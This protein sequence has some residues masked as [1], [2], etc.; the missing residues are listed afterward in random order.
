MNGMKKLWISFF[1]C[2]FSVYSQTVSVDDASYSSSQLV[3]LLLGNSCVEVSNISTSSPQSVAFFTNNGSSFPIN[4]GIL[5]RNGLATHTQGLYSGSNLSSQINTNSDAYLQ[6][7]SNSVGQTASITDVGFLEFDFIPLSS[8]FSFDFLFASNEYGQYQCG[9]SDV[10]AFVLTNLS[11]G[12]STNLAVIPGTSTPVTVKDIRDAAYN[13]ACASS[14][15][16]FFSVYN[17]TNVAASTINM[18][19]H[20]VVMN[21]SSNVI[22]NTPYKIRLVIGDYN[23]SGYDSAV[24]LKAGSFTTTLNLGSDRIICNGDTFTLNTN[25]DTS[26]SYTW[27]LNG[28]PINGATNSSYQ[29]TQSGTYTVEATKGSCIITDTIVFSDLAV[30]NPMN[31]QTCNTGDAVYSYDLTINNETQLGIDPATYDVFYYASLADVAANTPIGTPNAFSSDGGQIVYLKIRNVQTGNFC[32]TVY[33]FLLLVN[34]VPTATQPATVNLCDNSTT[35]NYTLNALDLE[36]LNGLLQTNYTVSYYATQAEATTGMNPITVLTIPVG[37]TTTTVYIRMHDNLNPNCFDTTSVNFTVNPLPLVSDFPDPIECSSF[38]LPVIEHG[39]YYSGTGGTGIHYNPGDVLTNGGTYYIYSGPDTSGCTNETT[40]TL[41]LIDEYQLALNNCGTFTVPFPPFNVGAFYT[42]SG[43]PSGGGTLIAPGTEYVNTTQTNQTHD[44]YYYAELD[45]AFCRD[46]LFTINVR[47]IPLVDDPADVVT[48]DSYQLPALVNGSYFSGTGGTGT[49]LF[50]GQFITSS[51]TVYVYATN[52]FCSKENSFEVKIVD[53]SLYTTIHACGQYM[54]PPI[55]F[56]G[57]FTQPFGGGVSVDPNIPITSSQII[58]YFAT[59]TTLPNC[60]NNLKYN[61]IIHELPVVDS[62]SS[63]TFCGQ[64][65]L[66]P[67]TNGV[68]FTLPGGPSVVGQTQLFA[69]QIID[70]TGTHLNPGTYYI[71]KSPDANGCANQ[72]TFTI[73]LNPYPL[74]DGVLDRVVC[75]PYSI[76]TPTNGTI[77]T[78]PGGPNGG[79]SVVQSTDVFSETKTFYLYNIVSATGCEIS[80]PFTVTYGGLNLPNYP[81]VFVCE[82]QNYM[83]PAL[84]H[85]PPT[86]VN[87][88]IGYYFNPGGVNPVPNGFVFNSPNT[89][90]T[91][92]VYAKNGDRVI[93]TQEDSFVV[94]VSQT[95]SLPILVTFNEYCG[96]YTLPPLPT[97][98]FT[99]GYYTQSGGNGLINP[100]DYTFSTPGNYIIYLYATA[101]NN[102]NC[103]DEKPITFTIHPLLEID[104]QDGFICVNPYTNETLQNY[105][106]DTGLNNALFTVN[107]YLNGALISTGPSF[108]ANQAGIYDVKFTKLTPDSGTDCNYQDTTVTVTASSAAI[109]SFTVSSAFEDEAYIQ[110]NV[111]GGY[112]QYSFQLQY[113]DGSL[114]AFQSSPVFSNLESGTY[115]VWIRD[116]LAG[117]DS[118]KIGPI[119][120]IN[121]PLFFTP[122]GDSYNDFW[123]IWDLKYQP[124]ATIAI[125]D[126]YG[127]LIKQFS[128]A[129]QSWDGTYNGENLPSTDYWFTV[130][131]FTDDN[132]KV[133]FKSHFTLKR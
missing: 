70:L 115:Y 67:L 119:H 65:I 66:P 116:D 108:T 83:L 122:N 55:P 87:Y 105:T 59:T 53:T 64:F 3:S 81:D 80:K 73:N 26:F 12:V 50:A 52:G 14:N 99:V 109:A 39:E 97:G 1:L 113:P 35:I 93:C 90:I 38:T 2:S 34:N 10:F 58:Y 68:Y 60:T 19:G 111:T 62:L 8:T 124:N 30:S 85:L 9:F 130:E 25:L 69:G 82:S 112:G 96:S 15:S 107:W 74:T 11:T 54:L 117:C 133:V 7:L 4:Q 131:Y 27:Y 121:Y 77:Y 95:P 79:G 98:N 36:V 45:G 61:I 88:S 132:Q 33:S 51:Q 72:S 40:F 17:P 46:E 89:D 29:V 23:D 47:P 28:T 48:C 41:F 103:Y 32:D 102:I 128:P 114:G 118:V 129:K 22:P 44:I 37:T 92:Y 110:V 120:I 56:G 106:V 20:T 84:S 94:H 125:F 100:S 18:R 76:P 13:A 101:I 5:I 86:P 123:N 78:L 43:G 6:N 31:L 42:A 126:R 75:V 91:I 57:Y 71:Y 16:T 63:G 21:A 127:K 104:L 24:F 49:P